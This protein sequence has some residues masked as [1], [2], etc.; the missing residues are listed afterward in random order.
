MD[1]LSYPDEK[2]STAMYSLAGEGSLK[3]RI[4]EAYM[5]F[6]P[7]TGKDFKNHPDL[8]AKFEELHAALT[9]VKTGDPKDGYV[10]TTLDSMTTEQLDDL[11]GKIVGLALAIRRVRGD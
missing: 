9:A 7:I 4:M 1:D 5:S 2:F 11:S 8:K 10:K 6:H 3:D